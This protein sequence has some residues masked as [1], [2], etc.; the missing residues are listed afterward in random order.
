LAW[1][2]LISEE[3]F[4]RAAPRS[5]WF[6]VCSPR[7]DHVWQPDAADIEGSLNQIEGIESVCVTQ[8][9]ACAMPKKH[10]HMPKALGSN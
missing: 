3:I 1:A 10:Q 5:S 6:K 9:I 2:V 4:N 7:T 8:A